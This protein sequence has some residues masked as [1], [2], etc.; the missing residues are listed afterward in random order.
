VALN[1]VTASRNVFGI[2]ADGTGSTGGINMTIS[3]GEVAGNRQDGI[4]AT[5]P[6]GGAP[7]GVTVKN[8]KWVNNNI[9]IRSVGTGVTVRV[10]DSTI[11]GNGTGLTFGFGGALL[12]S[13]TMKFRP[14]A[15]TARSPVR[16]GFNSKRGRAARACRMHHLIRFGGGS[17]LSLPPPSLASG[18]PDE[19]STA[20]AMLWR[21]R[22]LYGN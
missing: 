8:T 11:I 18:C 3:D 4:I 7:I 1:R 14:T 9:G 13:E 12:S 10:S 19:F 16:S 20:P 21:A 2:A 5:T 6:G 15:R 22:R 17:A